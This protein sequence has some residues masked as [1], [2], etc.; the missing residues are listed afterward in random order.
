MS[1]TI[2]WKNHVAPLVCIVPSQIT[3][4]TL[5]PH[6]FGACW[7]VS[8]IQIQRQGRVVEYVLRRISSVL[9][10]NQLRGSFYRFFR[11]EYFNWQ[12]LGVQDS[13]IV[14]TYPYVPIPI[15]TIP[16]LPSQCLNF[17]KRE[18]RSFRNHLHYNSVT[19]DEILGLISRNLSI[20]TTVYTDFFFGEVKEAFRSPVQTLSWK[21]EAVSCH[22]FSPSSPAQLQLTNQ[23]PYTLIVCK[24]FYDSCYLVTQS[25]TFCS[26]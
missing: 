20:V 26:C 22:I 14:R 16:F 24:C 18:S 8:L 5:L 25:F 11:Q 7:D 3:Q 2:N 21:S 15:L 12:N 13:G 4:V 6:P 17:N 23:Y 19:Q 1:V 10:V 9:Q